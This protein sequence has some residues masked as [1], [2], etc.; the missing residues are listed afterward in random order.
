[1]EVLDLKGQDSHRAANTAKGKRA[2]TPQ[3]QLPPDFDRCH[4]VLSQF[5]SSQPWSAGKSMKFF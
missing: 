3:E 4:R 2:S 1:V 5:A